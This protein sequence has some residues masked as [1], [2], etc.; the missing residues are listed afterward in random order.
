MAKKH[1]QGDRNLMAA[2]LN[3]QEEVLCKGVWTE[4][5]KLDGLADISRGDKAL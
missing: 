3:K 4:V 2:R 5:Y 1:V